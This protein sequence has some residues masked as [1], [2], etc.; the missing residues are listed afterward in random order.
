[1]DK[2]EEDSR[3]RPFAVLKRVFS[4]GHVLVTTVPRVHESIAFSCLCFN[5]LH[6]STLAVRL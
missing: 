4:D 3:G 1:V 2:P 6:M 5:L